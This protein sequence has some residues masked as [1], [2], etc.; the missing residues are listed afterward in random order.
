MIAQAVIRAAGG[1]FMALT[2]NDELAF[3]ALL[4]EHQFV[5]SLITMYREFQMR[6]VGFAMIL[7]A[8]VLGLIGSAI[9]ASGGSQ[10]DKVV[11]YA[12]ELIC[13]P[14][15]LVILVFSVMEVRILRAS[16]FLSKRTSPTIDQL[17][18]GAT[19]DDDK[20]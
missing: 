18:K 10:L 15:A 11:S 12:T 13:F 3:Q 1:R 14:A 9:G 19:V 7:Y 4:A 8:A 17:L 16:L 5:S 20:L 2:K 6:A